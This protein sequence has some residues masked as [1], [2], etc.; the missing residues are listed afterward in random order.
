LQPA[1]R[2]EQLSK[3]YIIGRRQQESQ[4]FRELID[5]KFRRFG[6]SLLNSR[7]DRQ[8]ENE[9]RE[10]W[11]LKDLSFEIQPGDRMGI[12]GQNGAGKSTLLKILSRITD[13]TSGRVRIRGRVT[14][15]LEVGTGFHPELTGRENIFLA[16]SIL[17]MSR[18][19]IKKR[20]DAIVAFAE[21]EKFLDTPVKHYSSGMYVRLA[22]SVAAHLESEIL[23]VDEV[24]AV[25]DAAFQKKCLGKMESV[26][27]QGRTVVFVSHNMGAITRLCTRAFWLHGGRIREQ[28][29]TE[30]VVSR[31]LFASGD[32]SGQLIVPD[33][34]PA[35]GNP[36][37]CLKAVRVR[38][39]QKDIVSSLDIRHPF[40]I[41]LEYILTA[42]I[43]GLRV[44]FRLLTSEGVVVFSTTDQD[45]E[46]LR[47]Q[48]KAAGAYLSRCQIPGGFLNRWHYFI[49]V[50]IDVPMVQSI[51][52]IDQALSFYVEATGGLVGDIPDN[53]LGVVC[54]LLPWTVESL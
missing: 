32:G 27:R 49:S 51:L 11:A 29:P 19:E 18:G 47:N 53:R 7:R 43:P 2:A 4:T 54:P 6:R 35:A 31:Y 13:P 28:G 3:R 12:I 40:S 38:N 14:S 22:F 30:E 50:G 9:A 52:F 46:S 23:L 10:F 44:G 16:A 48:P 24:L 15:L 37:F 39:A 5:A 8:A 42:P 17:G 41:D 36:A 26:T 25:G 34:A 21:T 20:F 33:P 1:I 45:A